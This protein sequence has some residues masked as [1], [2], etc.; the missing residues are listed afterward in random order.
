MN[1]SER[2]IAGTPFVR[3]SNDGFPSLFWQGPAGWAPDGP[4]RVGSEAL[5]PSIASFGLAALPK[6][7]NRL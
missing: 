4:G 5:R 2:V 1:F 6:V 3:W 7:H